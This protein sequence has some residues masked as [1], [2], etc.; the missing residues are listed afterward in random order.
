MSAGNPQDPKELGRGLIQ[1]LKDNPKQTVFYV[2]EIGIF[3]A[4]SV[5]TVPALATLGLS[6][7]GPVIGKSQIHCASCCGLT[8]HSNGSFY[9]H[10]LG[11]NSQGR[12]L[13]CDSAERRYGR[14]WRV[15]GQHDG[16][17][18]GF[19]VFGGGCISHTEAP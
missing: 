12:E 13:A 6:S 14:L 19:G 17:G 11:W 8:W 10:E 18:W 3:V 7:G 1:W 4:P 15:C 2:T 16:P 9:L 5:V